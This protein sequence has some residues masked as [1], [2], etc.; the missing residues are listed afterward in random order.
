MPITPF[1]VYGAVSDENSNLVSNILVQILDSTLGLR[2]NTLTDNQGKYILDLSNLSSDYSGGD[3]IVVYVRFNGY[4]GESS[5]TVSGEGGINKNI[6]VLNQ[7]TFSTFR[8]R[9]WKVFTN[10]ARRWRLI[11]QPVKTGASSRL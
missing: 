10:C 11:C 8:N 7:V 1:L 5:F 3:S 2:I 9:A 4:V 6:S